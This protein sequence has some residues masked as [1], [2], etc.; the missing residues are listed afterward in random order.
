MVELEPTDHSALYLLI[1]DAKT[2]V[3]F[4]KNNVFEISKHIRSFILRFEPQNPFSYLNRLILLLYQAHSMI[5]PISHSK[6]Q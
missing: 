6:Q 1:I 4:R 2:S 5:G 3:F